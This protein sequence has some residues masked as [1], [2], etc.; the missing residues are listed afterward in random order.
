MTWYDSVDLYSLLATTDKDWFSITLRD[1]C[2]QIQPKFYDSADTFIGELIPHSQNRCWMPCFRPPPEEAVFESVHPFTRKNTRCVACDVLCRLEC[3]DTPC[4]VKDIIRCSLDTTLAIV[5]KSN[6]TIAV[7]SHPWVHRILTLSVLQVPTV[8]FAFICSSVGTMC[9]TDSCKQKINID[10]VLDQLETIQ[11]F[12]MF[13]SKTLFDE[14]GILW[15]VTSICWTHPENISLR[16][17]GS[18]PLKGGLPTT[19]P[20]LLSTKKPD[21]TK[22]NT[23]ENWYIDQQWGNINDTK[24]TRRQWNKWMIIFSLWLSD[25]FK[26]LITHADKCQWKTSIDAVDWLITR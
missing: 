6:T 16:W 7:K 26:S 10:N 20:W 18:L 14:K 21:L 17:I 13:P 12:I 4:A 15:D 2:G 9:L 19:N 11:G 3:E 24:M 1:N 23:W 5:E 8:V 25:S 22:K